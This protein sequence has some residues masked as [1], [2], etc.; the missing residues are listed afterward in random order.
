MKEINLKALYKG[1]FYHV[2]T[3]GLEQVTLLKDE[4]ESA[5]DRNESKLLPV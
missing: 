1:N 3:D 2:C 5:E 4:E